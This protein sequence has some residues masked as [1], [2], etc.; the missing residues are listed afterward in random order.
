MTRDTG[1]EHGPGDRAARNL[2]RVLALNAASSAGTGA[3][4]ALFAGPLGRLFV[5][6]GGTLLGLSPAAWILATGLGLLPFAAMVALAAARTVPPRGGVGAIIVLDG[7]WVA[8]SALLL[9]LAGTALTW[10]AWIAI[11]V[12]ADAVALFAFLQAR[13][14]RRLDPGPARRGGALGVSA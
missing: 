4:M 11:I 13:F 3:L 14:L 12:V 8:G 5:P 2:R 7:A 9:V 1:I 10:P 6:D